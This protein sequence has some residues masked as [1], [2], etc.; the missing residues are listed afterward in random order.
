MKAIKISTSRIRTVAALL[1]LC[2]GAVVAKS[3]VSRTLVE[4]AAVETPDRTSFVCSLVAASGLDEFIRDRY[5]G[6][7]SV[8]D[9]GGSDPSSEINITPRQIGPSGRGGA[10]IGSGNKIEVVDS[11]GR[12][13][14]R[15]FE[16]VDVKPF[17]SSLSS[18]TVVGDAGESPVRI[19]ST[20]PVEGVRSGDAVFL[21]DAKNIEIN[22][23]GRDGSNGR[24]AGVSAALQVL[25]G[26]L[27][28]SDSIKGLVAAFGLGPTISEP[29]ISAADLA[30]S[31]GRC[32][33][34]VG[35]DYQA[36][37]EGSEEGTLIAK[38]ERAREVLVA[39]GVCER[40]TSQEFSIQTVCARPPEV[41]AK[42]RCAYPS[43][44]QQ[45]PLWRRP[46]ES[47]RIEITCANQ[48]PEGHWDVRCITESHAVVGS[49]FRVDYV[50]LKPS[51][52]IARAMKR[53]LLHSD[54]ATVPCRVAPK[55]STNSPITVAEGYDPDNFEYRDAFPG[56][57]ESSF[58][59][60]VPSAV[61]GSDC[62]GRDMR[63]MDYLR[64]SGALVYKNERNA[65]PGTADESVAVRAPEFADY[66]SKDITK[67]TYWTDRGSEVD[68]SSR[69]SRVPY[70]VLSSASSVP[71]HYYLLDPS[72]SDATDAS[73]RVEYIRGLN[74]LGYQ[75][76][77]IDNAVVG[78][79]SLRASRATLPLPEDSKHYGEGDIESILCNIT[80]RDAPDLNLDAVDP[81]RQKITNYSTFS[82]SYRQSHEGASEVATCRA[83]L[84]RYKFSSTSA[85]GKLHF[86]EKIEYTFT[87]LKSGVA[88]KRPA[89]AQPG[90]GSVDSMLRSVQDAVF[91]PRA[92]YIPGDLK[93]DPIRTVTYCK[94][95]EIDS[96]DDSLI[97]NDGTNVDLIGPEVFGGASLSTYNVSQNSDFTVR[98]QS[99]EAEENK[100]PTASIYPWAN[101]FMRVRTRNPKTQNAGCSEITVNQQLTANEKLLI[102]KFK[103][104]NGV[105]ITAGGDKIT[106]YF[107]PVKVPR[108]SR[109]ITVA[110]S[111]SPGLYLPH[112]N[113]SP[114]RMDAVG[115]RV[116]LWSGVDGDGTPVRGD[117]GGS[118]ERSRD[119]PYAWQSGFSTIQA[120]LRANYSL[121]IEYYAL[122]RNFATG[123]NLSFPE[124][125]FKADKTINIDGG[126]ASSEADGRRVKGASQRG[127]PRYIKTLMSL[128]LGVTD[129]KQSSTT[130]GRE[131]VREYGDVL[132]TRRVGT[133]TS[134]SGKMF[135][136][137]NS[138]SQ[139]IKYPT[140]LI[141]RRAEK[142]T[143]ANKSRYK[144][145]ADGNVVAHPEVSDSFDSRNWPVDNDTL[146]FTEPYI[147]TSMTSFSGSL[148]MLDE[149]IN[150]AQDYNSF[151]AQIQGNTS[152]SRADDGSV[153]WYGGDCAPDADATPYSSYNGYDLHATKGC[154][155][156]RFADVGNRAPYMPKFSEWWTYIGRPPVSSS[157]RQCLTDNPSSYC[158]EYTDGDTYR[159]NRPPFFVHNAGQAIIPYGMTT[160]IIRNSAIPLFRGARPFDQRSKGGA[161]WRSTNSSC[162]ITSGNPADWRQYPETC[163]TN[164]NFF[165]GHFLPFVRT[166]PWIFY[167]AKNRYPGG[168]I[169]KTYASGYLPERPEDRVFNGDGLPII[170]IGGSDFAGDQDAIIGLP[171]DG[172]GGALYNR[173]SFFLPPVGITLKPKF[174]RFLSTFNSNCSR[175][176]RAGPGNSCGFLSNC[177][178]VCDSGDDIHRMESAIHVFHGGTDGNSIN[179]FGIPQ[180]SPGD[181]DQPSRTA[182]DYAWNEQ[183]LSWIGMSGYMFDACEDDL[184]ADSVMEPIENHVAIQGKVLV[185]RHVAHLIPGTSDLKK[186]VGFLP[187]GLA[188]ADDGGLYFGPLVGY[189][190][191]PVVGG[192][193]KGDGKPVGI[194]STAG[195]NGLVLQDRSLRTAQGIATYSGLA[196]ALT[197][198][199]WD[200]NSKAITRGP[201]ERSLFTIGRAIADARA[202]LTTYGDPTFS[203]EPE[204]ALVPE[205]LAA[206][207]LHSNIQLAEE[208]A[209]D[210]TPWKQDQQFD[211]LGADGRPLYFDHVL[212]EFLPDGVKNEIRAQKFIMN[213][214]ASTSSTTDASKS[215]VYAR[216][217]I[218]AF[219]T[220]VPSRMKIAWQ[221]DENSI[222]ATVKSVS[223]TD[224]SANQVVGAGEDGTL[225]AIVLTG[226]EG[227]SSGV[228]VSYGA[229][230]VFGDLNDSQDVNGVSVKRS[231][232]IGA[233]IIRN[234]KLH[235]NAL[236]GASSGGASIGDFVNPAIPST[237]GPSF[238]FAE[239]YC[240]K[241]RRKWIRNGFNFKIE[242]E[243][244]ELSYISP[245]AKICQSAA[246]YGIKPADESCYNDYGD[247]DPVK[248]AANE[249]ALANNV[250]VPFPM[251]DVAGNAGIQNIQTDSNVCSDSRCRPFRGFESNV[252][253]TYMKIENE[254]VDTTGTSVENPPQCTG[255]TKVKSQVYVVTGATEKSIL[256]APKWLGACGLVDSDPSCSGD[257]SNP[258]CPASM[259]VQIGAVYSTL[260]QQ[261]D[262]CYNPITGEA[263]PDARVSK[264]QSACPKP[265]GKTGT[266]I[267]TV[268]EQESADFVE[269]GTVTG[270]SF[271]APHDQLAPW[272]IFV[273]VHEVD[274]RTVEQL[275]PDAVSSETGW[276]KESEYTSSLSCPAIAYDPRNA[277][278]PCLGQ[279]SCS[280]DGYPRLVSKWAFLEVGRRFGGLDPYYVKT[281]PKQT[282][283]PSGGGALGVASAADSCSWNGGGGNSPTGPDDATPTLRAGYVDDGSS[284]P[285][286]ADYSDFA[287]AIDYEWTGGSGANVTDRQF[288]PWSSERTDGDTLNAPSCAIFNDTANVSKE[289]EYPIV[290]DDEGLFAIGSDSL[291]RLFRANALGTPD[292][293]LGNPDPKFVTGGQWIQVGAE[294][295]QLTKAN[296]TVPVECIIH[297]NSADGQDLCDSNIPLTYETVEGFQVAVRA[298][299]GEHGGNAGT[300]IALT[301]FK[302][303]DVVIK[304]NGG[305]AGAAGGTS[306]EGS[307]AD[308]ELVCYQKGTDP[309]LPWIK[310]YRF[311]KSVITVAPASAGNEGRTATDNAV[312]GWGV[313]PGAMKFLEK[314]II[315]RARQE[316][317]Q[318]DGN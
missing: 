111:L 135:C 279:P 241:W 300:A 219:G 110:Q 174:Q 98:N 106:V 77:T 302:P 49:A 256:K 76:P 118:I 58:F 82:E 234:Q 64:L 127:K 154:M 251:C 260:Y 275:A 85:A 105:L 180:Y 311:N 120:T 17:E 146:F 238:E 6:V 183:A 32:E 71:A 72:V 126:V 317:Q 1:A 20:S 237:V 215:N 281:Q 206:F 22:V 140:K 236:S 254:S 216:P 243:S 209:S 222:H 158:F 54:G 68:Q 207:F 159:E 44:V 262:S 70:D 78:Y 15:D 212:G 196:G 102:E 156:A 113:V 30:D 4:C 39:R 185:D 233:E 96:G 73:S 45:A 88:L 277:A 268:I 10:R 316:N 261:M 143:D 81:N 150:L 84:T 230:G 134:G 26:E 315:E 276:I 61:L 266:F 191:K 142:I 273:G 259:P 182:F 74:F 220:S 195:T 284:G 278:D 21:G 304:A 203:Y 197:N 176:G 160:E 248:R 189:T 224:G 67:L 235:L 184:D 265:Q 257:G 188:I 41:N 186:S 162:E 242:K 116:D 179:E 66:A 218:F 269:E 163:K 55:G 147:P 100:S 171:Y 91:E 187:T 3:Q 318:L 94:K 90:D 308:R 249:Q 14:H 69:P 16:A 255:G 247:P 122:P 155:L 65:M 210:A 285:A 19:N 121:G 129:S 132:L 112:L 264:K 303:D 107:S 181:T 293:S 57:G 198:G 60:A 152:I 133:P 8:R 169:A 124:R 93:V 310:V 280:L 101:S 271:P 28:T 46:T 214:F 226:V 47:K 194:L 59:D 290:V 29:N 128:D 211:A 136:R 296:S 246:L 2:G 103:N 263:A 168:G 307:T 130:I 244:P 292:S 9:D 5:G 95:I 166:L 83:F 193:S 200:W 258:T 313:M 299:S 62:L 221:W 11:A 228:A 23:A 75:A 213:A 117:L 164:Y 86:R 172:S 138:L 114:M 297:P 192:A 137:A 208:K 79:D 34:V 115:D 165:A 153:N 314:H 149:P 161:S 250:A 97:S 89:N 7:L 217:M 141:S 312:Y 170:P 178:D 232:G 306:M 51:D 223:T 99:A 35:G 43:L 123:S 173:T 108:V 42:I 144:L 27:G 131:N 109:T 125:S 245:Y 167:G 288:T 145:F 92:I 53:P 52:D 24:S 309:L 231:D 151:L 87:G 295:R 227:I 239:N 253:W 225:H 37:E 240:S 252:Y 139:T 33:A 287:Y 274:R 56:Q 63:K 13:T 301:T 104:L 267:P 31:A 204:I 305:K 48:I 190:L 50:S 38:T 157:E 40:Q 298:E 175:V 36:L 294:Q 272:S 119:D 25:R 148:R 205:V 289:S 177:E 199:N 286:P 12:V 282:I 201:S 18:V 202:D 291:R 80:G 283:I 229:Q 270:T